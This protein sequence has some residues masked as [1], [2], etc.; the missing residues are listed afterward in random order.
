MVKCCTTVWYWN[1]Y[2][3]RLDVIS[4]A[5][6]YLQSLLQNLVSIDKIIHA[7]QKHENTQDICTKQ[8]Y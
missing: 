6:N 7:F 5:L 3:L 8:I 4:Y 1:V 2:S